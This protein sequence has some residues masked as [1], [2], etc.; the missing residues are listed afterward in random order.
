MGFGFGASDLYTA[1]ALALKVILIVPQYR[2]TKCPILALF[3]LALQSSIA[4]RDHAYFLPLIECSL[5]HRSTRDA[6]T[7]CR[8]SMI[9]QKK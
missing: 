2:A 8:S 9:S 6:E 7:R 1:A 5:D 3:T 4:A